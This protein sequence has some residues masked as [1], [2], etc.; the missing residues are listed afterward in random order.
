MFRNCI[1]E[2]DGV[3]PTKPGVL[4]AYEIPIL[5][6][7]P[8]YDEELSFKIMIHNSTVVKKQVRRYIYKVI[9][10]LPNV[11]KEAKCTETG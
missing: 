9:Y 8:W 1:P 3:L 4:G 5:C 10:F 11:N 7:L 2:E 6:L